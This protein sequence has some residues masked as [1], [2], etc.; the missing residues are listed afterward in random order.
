MLLSCLGRGVV[1][2]IVER[3][4]GAQ[5]R[6]WQTARVTR[7]W[8][9]LIVVGAGISWHRS[10]VGGVIIWIPPERKKMVAVRTLF[11]S[12]LQDC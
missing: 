7:T 1:A 6:D 3:L 4:L 5:L 9:V 11:E 12:W 2:G 10:G 8:S